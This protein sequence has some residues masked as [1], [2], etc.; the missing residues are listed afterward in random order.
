MKK[1]VATGRTVEEAI[2]SALVRLGVSRSQA[3]I[4][5]ISE[6]V[7]G[8]FGFIGGRDAEVEVCVMETP[9][10]MAKEFLHG[11]LEKMG[12]SADVTAE[13][14]L[15]EDGAVPLA[16]TCAEDALPIVIGRHGS[17]LDS[18]Q[19]LV[20]LVANRNAHSVV[21][22]SV[23]AGGYRQRRRENLRRMADQAVERAVRLGRPVSLEAMPS[24]DRK[25]IHTYLQGRD[26]ITTLSEGQ[27]PYRRVKVA[28]KRNHFVD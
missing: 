13:N 20:N 22:F 1:V 15:T 12:I 9:L 27:E 24:A 5:V 3:E 17:T 18:M 7:K 28:P 16:I 10:D 23:D 14:Q 8:L 6:P 2:T 21:K 4:R 19:Y 25:W 26:D 11:L